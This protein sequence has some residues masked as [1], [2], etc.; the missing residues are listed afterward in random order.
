MITV[1]GIEIDVTI[2]PIGSH[3]PLWGGKVDVQQ[4]G[5]NGMELTVHGIEG[6]PLFFVD[7]V[8]NKHHLCFN[9]VHHQLE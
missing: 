3:G 7:D 8:T 6:D 5:L 4:H 2:E 1:R 9:L